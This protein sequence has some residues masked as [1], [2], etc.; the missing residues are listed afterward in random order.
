MPEAGD[1]TGASATI[2]PVSAS[3]HSATTRRPSGD[4]ELRYRRQV[5]CPTCGKRMRDNSLPRHRRN[6]HP[7][8]S[9]PAL[10][11]PNTEVRVRAD[12]TWSALRCVECRQIIPVGTPRNLLVMDACGRRTR[13]SHLVCP[14]PLP[15]G[16]GGSPLHPQEKRDNSPPLG[17]TGLAL[18]P[19]P[20]L[21]PPGNP[22]A[23]PATTGDQP[24]PVISAEQLL[25]LGILSAKAGE[26]SIVLDVSGDASQVLE[27]LV[28][29]ELVQCRTCKDLRGEVFVVPSGYRE[30]HDIEVHGDLWRRGRLLAELEALKSR[31]EKKGLP[32]RSERTVLSD[33]SSTPRGR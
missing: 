18:T 23:S 22:P 15:V 2:A 5:R 7:E 24:T 8:I 6:R 1:V 33:P 29:G 11:E 16:A 25:E 10:E 4:Q 3:D 26:R 28:G 32:T 13:W 31:D 14:S 12:L 9:I 27:R 30:R 17:P 20:T 19:Y 21:P